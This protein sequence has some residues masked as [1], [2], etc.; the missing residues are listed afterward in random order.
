MDGGGNLIEKYT[1]DAFGMPTITDWNGNAR[2]QSAYGNRFM[3][4]GR[5]W[6]SELG[7]YDYRNRFYHPGLGRFLQKDP[8]GLAAGDANLFRYCGGDPVNRNDPSGLEPKRPPVLLDDGSG[9]TTSG[10]TVTSTFLPEP[11]T[12][13]GPGD[14]RGGGNLSPRGDG[15]GREGRLYAQNAPPMSNRT[16]PVAPLPEEP[17]ELPHDEPEWPTPKDAKRSM[18]AYIYFFSHLFQGI[19]DLFPSVSY[20]V[21]PPFAPNPTPA[22]PGS[23][24]N[25]PGPSPSGPPPPGG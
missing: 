4:T 9:T 18:D 25:P 12:T 23:P 21:H 22:P 13:F 11:G 3:F 8:L 20:D 16:V 2:S 17:E 6:I 24:T 5:E 19:A 7:I 14:F 1:Y 10:V 15:G